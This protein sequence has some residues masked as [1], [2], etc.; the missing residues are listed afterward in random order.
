MSDPLP[1]SNRFEEPVVQPHELFEIL[2]REHEGKLR[3]FVGALVRDPG[4]MDDLVQ[5]SFLIAWRNLDRYDRKLPFGPWLRGIARRLCLAHH[6][7][8]AAA[9]SDWM[10][11]EKERGI[12]V[13]SS[14]MQFPYKDA[15]INVLDTPGHEDFS[16]DTYRTLI[17]ADSAIMVIDAGKGV[18]NVMQLT[19]SEITRLGHLPG[20]PSAEEVENDGLVMGEMQRKMMEKIEEL[21]LYIIQQQEEIDQLKQAERP[22]ARVNRAKQGDAGLVLRARRELRV[23]RGIRR[24]QR[25]APRERS[26]GESRVKRDLVLE[27]ELRVRTAGSDAVERA[28]GLTEEDRACRGPCG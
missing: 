24:D 8:G 15:I 18:K 13:T 5:E 17:A 2:V 28:H 14:A 25:G 23:S 26:F 12:S 1:L 7:K 19:K 27:Q 11:M 4:A 6:R 10:G 9:T 21:T 3:S 22:A 16:E 20:I